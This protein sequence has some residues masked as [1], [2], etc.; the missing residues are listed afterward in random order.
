MAPTVS[1]SLFA[2]VGRAAGKMGYQSAAA[3]D[4]MQDG[5]SRLPLAA[6]I[7]LL[8]TLENESG[9]SAIGLRLGRLLGPAAFGIAGYIAM[10]GPTLAAAL[11]RV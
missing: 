1:R 8:R 3:T 7:A 5:E 2:E 9:D 4:D 10:A 11:P 6:L